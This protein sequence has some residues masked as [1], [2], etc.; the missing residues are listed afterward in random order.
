[1][2]AKGSLFPIIKEM[3]GGVQHRKSLCLG[4]PQDSA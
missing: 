2:E 1:M 3:G 4:G